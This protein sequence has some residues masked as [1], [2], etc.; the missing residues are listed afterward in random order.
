[1]STGLVLLPMTLPGVNAVKPLSTAN[2]HS[3]TTGPARAL[4]KRGEHRQGV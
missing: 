2:D 3:V 1:L 4:K